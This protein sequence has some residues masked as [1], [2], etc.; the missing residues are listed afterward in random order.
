MSYI[1]SKVAAKL[2]NRIKFTYIENFGKKC[3]RK[4]GTTGNWQ[5]SLI[6]KEG[7]IY[8]S[9]FFVY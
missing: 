1:K 5:G 2:S 6:L 3:T 8:F 7:L 4:S 9:F